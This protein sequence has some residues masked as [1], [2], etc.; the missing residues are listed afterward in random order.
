MKKQVKPK[1]LK[2]TKEQRKERVRESGNSYITKKVP[3][4][5]AYK[6]KKG[7]INENE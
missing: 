1:Y 7:K 3:G 2:E 4:K 6:R 5:K